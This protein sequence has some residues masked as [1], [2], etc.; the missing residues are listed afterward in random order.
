MTQSRPDC[1]SVEIIL[2]DGQRRCF[3]HE[4]F[5]RTDSTISG[6]CMQYDTNG[7]RLANGVE[8]D[9]VHVSNVKQLNCIRLTEVSDP[10]KTVGLGLLGILLVG[11]VIGIAV[12]PLDFSG[13]QGLNNLGSIR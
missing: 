3:P 7:R 5:I 9:A 4:S 10:A 2:K 13:L 1:D 6:F 8:Y 11:C 12:G